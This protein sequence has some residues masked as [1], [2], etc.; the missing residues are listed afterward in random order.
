MFLRA[1]VLSLALL[2]ASRLLGLARESALAAAFGASGAADLAVLML[3]LPDWLAGIAASGALAYVMLPAWAGMDPQAVA[4]TQRRLAR[5][6]LAMGVGLA[7]A[8][9]LLRFDVLDLLVPGLGAGLHEA[10]VAAILWSAAAVPLALLAS[11]WATRLQHER[12]FT[13]MYG[14]N[15]V[16]NGVLVAVLGAMVVSG[17]AMVAALGA[18][19]LAAMGLRLLWLRRRLVLG[20]YPSLRGPSPDEPAALPPAATWLWAAAAAGLPLTLPFVARSMASASGEGAL[21]TFNYA[22]K[23]VELPLMLAIQLVATLAFP[24][25]ARAFASPDGDLAAAVRP[26]FALAWS[27]ACA[28]AAA[29][30]VASPGL[31]QLLFGW[32]RMDPKSLQQVAELGSIGAFSLLPQAL[33]AVGLTVLA[34]QQRMHIAVAAYAAALFLLLAYPSPQGATVMA[35]L[36]LLFAGVAVVVLAALGRRLVAWLP[37]SALAA[38]FAALALSAWTRTHVPTM[39]AWPIAAQL[40]VALTAAAFVMAV[41]AA[42]S[43]DLRRALRR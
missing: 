26:A 3:T 34:A 16:V 41:A 20:C 38:A 33:A 22:W 37:W 13:G 10:G 24:H 5:V 29:L 35:Q 18:G 28:A 31:A 36:N 32:G 4:A 25:I 42:A 11:L 27:L 19:L 14:A 17:Q 30:V 23:L 8:L 12:D 9:A 7:A 40:A 2:L 1:G 6:L 43:A 39:P 21:A 15:L